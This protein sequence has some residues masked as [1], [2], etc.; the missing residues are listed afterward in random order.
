MAGSFDAIRSLF[1]QIDLADKVSRPLAALNKAADLSAEKLQ[2][3]RKTALLVGGA[4]AAVG[5]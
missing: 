1:V 2:R 3:V 4:M 5:A